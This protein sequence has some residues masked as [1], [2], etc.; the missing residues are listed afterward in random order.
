VRM[1]QNYGVVKGLKLAWD[2]GF[3]KVELKVDFNIVAYT[4]NN[5]GKGSVV[6]WR[7]SFISF[8]FDV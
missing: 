6:G 7:Y 2:R 1:K 4:L 5:G 3:K 8:T